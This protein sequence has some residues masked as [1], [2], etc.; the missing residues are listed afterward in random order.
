MSWIKKSWIF[1]P[2]GQFA[3]SQTHAQVPT[4]LLLDDYIRIYYAT[5]DINGRSLTSFI[6]VSKED[7][8]KILYIHNHP[9]LSLG[10]P[11]THDEN[12][13]M[14]G[15]V[16]AHQNKILLYYTGWSRECTVPYRVSIGLAKSTDG[17]LTFERLFDGP[18]ID[19]TPLEPYMTMSPFVLCVNNQWKMWYGS[20]IGWVKIKN[21]VEPIYIVKYAESKDGIH[22]IQNNISCLEQLHPL[23]ANTR[24]SV[25]QTPGGYEMWFS[26]RSS[27]DYRD[28]QG[29]YR[30]GYA[31]S[32]NGINWKRELSF[33]D[34]K[35]E[36]TGWNNS[37]IAYPNV[38]EYNSRKILLYNGN[39]FGRSGFG[40]AIWQD[41]IL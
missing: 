15:S 33:S 11:G 24:P 13:V 2:T 27:I 34:M 10:K 1:K 38:I 9:V 40:Y 30:I 28:G 22:W 25:L 31:V 19:R 41:L 16:I 5:R 36:I 29:A 20:G 23:E 18:I 8:S 35:P 14:V 17:G 37:M 12:G 21:K 39:G 3:W 7:P 4:A 32:V 6:N 26:F